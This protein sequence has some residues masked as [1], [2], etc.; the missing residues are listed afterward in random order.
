MYS[1]FQDLN[2]RSILFKECACSK[3]PEPESAS[4][5]IPG[6]EFDYINFL[7]TKPVFIL[8]KVCWRKNANLSKAQPLIAELM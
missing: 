1:N 4:R 5:R 7:R 8:G 2:F 6:L 3:A